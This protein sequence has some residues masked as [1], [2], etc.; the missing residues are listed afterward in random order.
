MFV[1]SLSAHQDLDAAIVALQMPDNWLAHR[2]LDVSFEE[3]VCQLTVEIG[4]PEARSVS[5][6]GNDSVAHD[7]PYD[8]AQFGPRTHT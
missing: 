7:R 4:F 5:Q 6:N 1:E 3:L 2:P 8:G